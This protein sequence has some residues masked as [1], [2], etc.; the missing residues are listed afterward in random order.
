MKLGFH[1]G[2]GDEKFRIG[3][4]KF[5]VDGGSSGPTM[6]TR[7]PYSHD[8]TLPRILSWTREEV[9][10][11]FDEINEHD[12]DGCGNGDCYLEVEFMVE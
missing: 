9:A 5:M 1:T 2:L 12:C 10:D 7:E 11:F 6:A 4:C 8:P 3:S